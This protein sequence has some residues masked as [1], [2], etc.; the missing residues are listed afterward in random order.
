MKELQNTF[1]LAIC[2]LAF[3]TVVFFFKYGKERAQSKALEAEN[4]AS[5]TIWKNGPSK[6]PRRPSA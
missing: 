5:Q 4:I 1:I 3:T 2:L 6:G